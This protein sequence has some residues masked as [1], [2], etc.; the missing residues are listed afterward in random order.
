MATNPSAL[1]ENSGRITPP[2]ANYPYGS[3]QNDTTGATGNGT[4]IAKPLMDDTYGLQQALLRASATA[5]SGSADTATDS[6]YMRAIVELGAG[7]STEYDDTGIENAHILTPV[8]DVQGVNDYFEGMVVEFEVLRTN[9]GPCTADVITPN[10]GSLGLVPIK[11]DTQGSFDPNPGD[12]ERF[13]RVRMVYRAGPGSPFFQLSRVGRVKMTKIETSTTFFSEVDALATVFTLVGGGGGGGGTDGGGNN[14][15]V[16]SGSG[17][18]GGGIQSYVFK[19]RRFDF[20]ITIGAGGLGGAA[21]NNDGASGGDTIIDSGIVI[22]T[23]TGGSGGT[24]MSGVGVADV[25][26]GGSGG[27]ATAAGDAI[28]S[29]G[30]KGSVGAVADGSPITVPFSGVSFLG[31]SASVAGGDGVDGVEFGSGGTG[32]F[33]QNVSTNNAGGNG[34]PGVVYV[35]EYL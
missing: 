7:R 26:D 4:P 28:T 14:T 34:A 11:T 12:L 6:Q 32:A 23:A 35:T 31:G 10:G 22:A 30:G 1:P 25:A 29:I 20:Q 2:D 15:A 5:P 21:G 13:R 16:C 3:A 19:E 8:G 27:T 24:G 9:T 18:G 33:S 17:G